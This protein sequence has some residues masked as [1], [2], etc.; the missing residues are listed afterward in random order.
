MKLLKTLFTTGIFLFFFFSFVLISVSRYNSGQM[1]YYDFG[2]FAHTIFQLSQF[3][4]PY[5]NHLVL[6]HVMFLGDH[7]NPSL[8][9]LA[10]LFW[11]THDLRVLLIQQALATTLT[12]VAI[13]LLAKKFLLPYISSLVLSIAYLMFAGT[14]NPLVTDW[15]PE[16]TAALFLLLFIYFYRFTHKKTL[17]II[18][19][20][21]FLG[22]KESNAITVIFV[23][24]WLLATDK[25]KRKETILLI[26]FSLIYTVT[27]TRF[28]IPVIAHHAYLYTPIIPNNPFQ[29]A[30]NFA[31]SPQ[32]INLLYQSFISYGFLPIL[33]GLALL[34]PL[35]E[36]AIRLVP[37]N[38]I[39]NNLTLGQHYNV[40]LGV[41][42]TLSTLQTFLYLQIYT[43]TK[44]Y[45]LTLTAAFLLISS[46]YTARK[47]TG[48]PINV[49]IN[50]AF[51][52]TFNGDPTIAE[53]ID[54]IPKQGSVMA[55]NNLLAYTANRTDRLY[56][57]NTDYKTISPK[58]VLFNLTPG[59]SVNNYYGTKKETAEAL[60]EQLQNDSTYQRASLLDPNTYLYIKK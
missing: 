36:L 31:N 25:A 20:L 47:I 37:N 22:F 8:A 49:I 40:L 30:T 2:I 7:F 16:P 14:Q 1:F 10:P 12:G 28:V 17:Y 41:L 52:Q 23:L 5:I 34:M 55:Q 46:L 27:I 33:S 38:T 54:K 57:L 48:S 35:A 39:F 50:P 19:F 44:P 29:L 32:K 45:L 56:L 9:L 59:A 15:H 53:I 11:V 43:K 26:I 4:T 51:Y 60:K 24:V 13:F 3:H 42:L 18:C 6:G 58:I 21:I